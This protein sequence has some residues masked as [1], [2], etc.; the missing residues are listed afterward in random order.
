M[1]LCK[2]LTQIF[3]LR[4]SAA[5]SDYGPGWNLRAWALWEG[6]QSWHSAGHYDLLSYSSDLRTSI[7]YFCC[8][9]VEKKHLDLSFSFFL[10]FSLIFLQQPLLNVIFCYWNGLENF[11]SKT[12]CLRSIIL[13]IPPSWRK[14][15]PN[16]KKAVSSLRRNRRNYINAPSNSSHF[17]YAPKMGLWSPSLSGDLEPRIQ[18]PSSL[19]P[20]L[21]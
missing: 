18:Q 1:L 10:R 16:G 7:D 4:N 8:K 2:F 15:H 17:N 19:L 12:F 3:S 6:D 20:C 11:G 9:N 14:F 5:W 13:K 21:A